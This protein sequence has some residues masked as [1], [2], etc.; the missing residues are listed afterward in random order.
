MQ[1]DAGS[2]FPSGKQLSPARTLHIIGKGDTIV[3]MGTLSS[4]NFFARPYLWTLSLLQ[5]AVSLSWTSSKTLLSNFTTEV[6]FPFSLANMFR[7]D[8]DSTTG[9][10]VPSKAN[11]RKYFK[12]L[13]DTIDAQPDKAD[14]WRDVQPPSL[15]SGTSTPI[16]GAA[17]P[18]KGSA[19]RL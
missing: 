11:W 7:A 19:G 8:T 6:S 12:G 16:S 14:A 17:T 15:A 3:S 1:D 10:F 5:N 13:F 18:T 9:H 4:V 2:Y